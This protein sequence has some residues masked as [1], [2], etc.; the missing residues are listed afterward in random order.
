MNIIE[1]LVCKVYQILKFETFIRWG[2]K[3]SNNGNTFD[4]ICEHH[5]DRLIDSGLR[6]VNTRV[7]QLKMDSIK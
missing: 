4:L 1:N 6:A 2:G 3:Q 5:T 7:S